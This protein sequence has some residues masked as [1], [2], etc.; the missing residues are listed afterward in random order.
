M[1]IVHWFSFEP[2]N[3]I[4]PYFGTGG[5]PPGQRGRD[6]LNHQTIR[7]LSGVR[8]IGLEQYM[9]GPYCTMLLADAGAEVIKIERPGKGRPPARN[10]SVRP[11]GRFH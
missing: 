1:F 6:P 7:P 2:L 8:V 10:S 9:A 5:Q 4:R 3:C 11:K